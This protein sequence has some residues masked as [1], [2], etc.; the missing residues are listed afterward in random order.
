MTRRSAADQARA[1]AAT[2]VPRAPRI[3]GAVASWGIGCGLL[4]FL[5]SILDLRVVLG[6]LARARLQDLLAGLVLFLGIRILAA[7]QLTVGVRTHGSSLSLWRA[8]VVNAIAGFYNLFFPGGLV[9]GAVRWY[10][11]SKDSGRPAEVLGTILFLRLVNTGFSLACGLAAVLVDNP[12][13]MRN[14]LW[15]ALTI[16][17]GS[18]ALYCLV[19]TEA[20]AWVESRPSRARSEVAALVWGGLRSVLRAL[21]QYRALPRRPAF[22]ILSVPV[23]TQ[24]LGAFMFFLT[25]RALGHSLPVLVWVWIV[26]LVHLIQWV[27]ASVSGLGLREGVLVLLLP[28]Y[29]VPPADALAFSILIFGYTVLLGLSGGILELKELAS[30]SAKRDLDPAGIRS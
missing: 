2:P 20:A 30:R 25:A 21:R 17:A 3:L 11:L 18:A 15:V 23:M 16:A 7:W 8:F 27:P 26:P 29:G 12:L 28:R 14:V 1:G 9:G 6:A 24:M 13:E 4:A 22:V 10:K 5:V 19:S